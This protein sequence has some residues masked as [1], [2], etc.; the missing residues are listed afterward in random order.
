MPVKTKEELKAYFQNGK[1]PS[2]SHYSDLMDT[3]FSLVTEFPGIAN[4]FLNGLGQFVQVNWNDVSGK[5]TSFSPSGHSARHISGGT[6]AIK[7]DDLALPDN[8]TD[9]NASTARHGLLPKLNGVA[10]NALLGNGS[11]GTPAPAAHNHDASNIVSG[12]ITGSVPIAAVLRRRSSALSI[13]SSGNTT[14]TFTEEITDSY[15]DMASISTGYIYA[16][17]AGFYA[18]AGHIQFDAVGN[19][20]YWRGLFLNTSNSIGV[21]AHSGGQGYVSQD[22]TVMGMCWLN[23]NEYAFMRAYETSGGKN[24]INA[25]FSMAKFA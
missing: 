13:A 19:S 15:N 5:P 11:W 14:I 18:I 12:F 1:V 17:V 24:V 3:I 6:D 10:N 4:Q 9:L 23:A 22:L 16:K 20:N 7:L 25:D 2:Q 8:N 21:I